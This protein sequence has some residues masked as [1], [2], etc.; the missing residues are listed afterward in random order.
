MVTSTSALFHLVDQASGW[1][2]FSH[3]NYRQHLESKEGGGLTA[4]EVA[5]LGEH[6]ALRTKL[7]Y[8]PLDQSFYTELSLP[9]ALTAS[10]RNGRLTQAQADVER[11]VLTHF[12][13][14][15][16]A[17][18]KSQRQ[19]TGAFVAGLAGRA[20]E[21]RA[22]ATKASRFFGG[23]S[24]E[25]PLYLVPAGGP[26]GGGG[27]YNGG[28]LVVE[29]GS[30]DPLYVVLHEGWHAFAAAERAALDAA[31]AATA[32]LDFETLSEGLAHAVSPGIFT[33]RGNR[34]DDLVDRLRDLQSKGGAFS[35]VAFLRFH[36]FGVALRPSLRDALDR[37]GT[38]ESYLPTALAIYRGLTAVEATREPARMD[39]GV[40]LFGEGL[41]PMAQ[42]IADAG[43]D[44][45]TRSLDAGALH[46]MLPKIRGQ[47][48]LVVV[49]VGSQA[50][51]AAFLALLTPADQAALA[52]ARAIAPG[53]RT[54][55]TP[56]GA[57]ITVMWIAKQEDA[58][59]LVLAP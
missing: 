15:G 3:R 36:L 51:P 44:V 41:K 39:T 27:G 53:Q 25:M 1:S 58:A 57:R 16:A 59:A 13:A 49:L 19:A 24:V 33:P 30:R 32:E 52:A 37:D 31:V 43:S 35:D 20:D 23:G 26:G 8:G 46:S 9:E 40:F 18:E 2:P 50:L 55:T 17:L 5:L 34:T 22:F 6:A 54:S 7:G 14:R 47:D 29:V 45:W 28:R 4:A 48:R 21:L 11:R 12:T 56:T 10:V 38:L 42:R